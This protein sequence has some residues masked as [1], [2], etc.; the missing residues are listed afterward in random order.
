MGG[1]ATRWRGALSQ[2]WVVGGA[3]GGGLLEQ[4]RSRGD[5]AGGGG[6]VES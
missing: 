2:P 1:G 3:G 4:M 5:G 6:E